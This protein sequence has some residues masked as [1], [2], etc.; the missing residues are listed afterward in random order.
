VS[1][2]TGD[3]LQRQRLCSL[4][5]TPGAEVEICNGFPGQCKLLVRGGNL[6]L[7]CEMAGQVLCEDTSAF[8]AGK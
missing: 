6:A 8:F 2:I 4:G 7:D 5:L 1:E 3:V